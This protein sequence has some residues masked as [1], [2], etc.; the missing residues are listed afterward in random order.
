MSSREKKRAAPYLW[1]GEEGGAAREVSALGV[2][3]VLFGKARGKEASLDA[4]LL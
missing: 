1:F 2:E 3:K 4:E